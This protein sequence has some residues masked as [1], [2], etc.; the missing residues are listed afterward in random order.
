MDVPTRV[1]GGDVCI[2][3]VA[4]GGLS[5]RDVALWASTAVVL[6]V[7]GVVVIAVVGLSLTGLDRMTGGVLF[8]MAALLPRS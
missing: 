3:I 2:A 8:L 1:R 6:G 4:L 7:L 5:G